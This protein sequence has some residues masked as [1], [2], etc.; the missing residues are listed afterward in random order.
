MV[1]GSTRKS[2]LWSS[3]KP[4]DKTPADEPFGASWLLDTKSKVSTGEPIEVPKNLIEETGYQG[5][6]LPESLSGRRQTPEEAAI[7]AKY[8]TDT[9]P[10]GAISAA[11]L[12]GSAVAAGN[13]ADIYKDT[14]QH[15]S[16]LRTAAEEK[17]KA[18]KEF[19]T[20]Q[21]AE[22]GIRRVQ[23]IADQSYAAREKQQ[24][25]ID[26]L[27]SKYPH[28][29]RKEVA[30][31][32][33]FGKKMLVGMLGGLA[34]HPMLVNELIDRQVKDND[35]AFANGLG[36]ITS[37]QQVNSN[38]LSLQISAYQEKNTLLKNQTDA[39]LN[40]AN[41]KLNATTSPAEYSKLIITRNQLQDA[42]NARV[43]ANSQAESAKKAAAATIYY[44]NVNDPSWI[45]DGGKDINNA[46]TGIKAKTEADIEPLKA[47]M[48]NFRA[49]AAPGGLASRLGTMLS[50][51]KD[52]SDQ[53]IVNVTNQIISMMPKEMQV[54]LQERGL[55]PWD[56]TGANITSKGQRNPKELAQIALDAI[57]N[58]R[59]TV[60]LHG[61][62]PMLSR[63]Q[64]KT[65][66]K[67]QKSNIK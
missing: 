36:R 42:A 4:M 12:Q 56:I 53:E 9:V 7:A 59:Y 63:D 64:V 19:G 3:Y 1:D 6:M 40:V 25:Q 55:L 13:I 24:Q 10:S 62:A 44:N 35:E 20:G 17:M 22:E 58:W 30:D 15:P 2:Y 57:D 32:W 39:A 67:Q 43:V 54:P 14:A 49:V 46:P 52:Y 37:Q 61:S 18:Y 41:E 29:T 47:L 50:K 31:S 23:S 45:P 26:D 65:I 38:D 48:P 33:G 60:S 27:N 66:L 51:P 21:G 28:M 11:P 8:Y 5:R 16:P 34:G